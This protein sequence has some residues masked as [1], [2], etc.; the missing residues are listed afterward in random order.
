MTSTGLDWHLWSLHRMQ[1]VPMSKHALS[2]WVPIQ[3][4]QMMKPLYHA[5]MP[6]GYLKT[7]ALTLTVTTLVPDETNIH[8]IILQLWWSKHSFPP[9]STQSGNQPP[10]A[11]EQLLHHSKKQKGIWS[12]SNPSACKKARPVDLWHASQLERFKQG[13]F[14]GS[15]IASGRFQPAFDLDTPS[16]V[17]DA[18]KKTYIRSDWTLRIQFVLRRVPS[19]NGRTSR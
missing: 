12:L 16:T 2:T 9:H 5:T 14:V 8:L 4:S 18:S 1:C 6:Q 15:S 3:P 17:K 19:H 10:P 13:H 7:R 11:D